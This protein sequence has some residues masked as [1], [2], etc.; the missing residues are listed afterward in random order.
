MTLARGN[1][2]GFYNSSS[3]LNKYPLSSFSSIMEPLRGGSPS[4]LRGSSGGSC[5]PGSNQGGTVGMLSGLG[6][7]SKK[8]EREGS[9]LFNRPNYFGDLGASATIKAVGGVWVIF[10]SMTTIF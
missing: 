9:P 10:R 2:G 4:G 5:T 7:G 3:D 1:A 8:N 6:N